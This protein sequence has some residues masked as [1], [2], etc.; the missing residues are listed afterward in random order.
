MTQKNGKS[1]QGAVQ[2]LN[3]QGSFIGP[4]PVST[5][6]MDEN[7]DMSES[8]TMKKPSIRDMLQEK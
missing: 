5:L 2:M 3:M 8:G 1:F 7:M 4:G 6:Q